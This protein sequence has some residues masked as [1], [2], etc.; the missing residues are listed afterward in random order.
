ML[1]GAF[2]AARRNGKAMFGSALIFQVITAVITLAIT[3]SALGR[4]S[5]NIFADSLSQTAPTEAQLNGLAGT[6]LQLFIAVGVVSIISALMEMVLQGA[7]VVPVLR[8]TL[9]R[10]TE[11][12]QMWRLVKPRIGSLLLLAL[13]YAAATF[14]AIAV[15]AGILIGLLVA[16]NSM[17]SSSGGL[18]ALGFGLL[19]SLPF[20]A[21]GIWVG[22]K[23]MLAPASIVVEDIG[24]FAAI[25]RSWQ[26]TR[27]NW[28]RTFG[29]AALA[30]IIA[31]VI[32]GIIT[33]PVTLLLG[34]LLPVMSPNP[35]QLMGTT[36]LATVISSLIGALVGAVT[37]AFQTGVMALI[38]VDL[39]MRRDG[40]DVTLLKESESGKDDGGIPGRGAPAPAAVGHYPTGQF[41]QGQQPPTQYPGQN[42]PAPNPPSQYPGQ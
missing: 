27:Q 30:A 42:P 21:A 20:L 32:G 29:I 38:Y 24:V 16:T 28:W 11:F 10:K 18:A 1:D 37:V 23:V 9:N 19:L 13:V 12:G 3:L 22:V 35:D 2:Q 15:Y 4:F 31:S 40:F 25:K 34:L 26:L 6:M 36:A 8:A 7:L 33:T 17:G 5:S 41:P 14:L 39:R